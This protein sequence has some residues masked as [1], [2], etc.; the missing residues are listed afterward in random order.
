ML[1]EIFTGGEDSSGGSEGDEELFTDDEG[2]ENEEDEEI[3]KEL[4]EN[5]NNNPGSFVNS[6]VPDLEFLIN[7][8][9]KV[10]AQ[11]WIGM[12]Y[13]LVEKL[14]TNYDSCRG[15]VASG[16][17]KLEGEERHLMNKSYKATF[18][19]WTRKIVDKFLVLRKVSKDEDNQ[20]NATTHGKDKSV[21]SAEETT[22]DYDDEENA[23]LSA[24][25]EIKA[26][27]RGDYE[28]D[29]TTEEIQ[30]EK[31]NSSATTKQSKTDS[32]EDTKKE[33]SVE[34]AEETTEETTE[35]YEDTTMDAANDG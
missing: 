32:G 23:G 30:T 21:E 13:N 12:I 3:L 22:Q 8:K 24:L 10:S 16:M 15:L 2:V 34:T 29:S 6:L 20:R 33:K 5:I 4:N 35:D 25:E 9:G 31:A 18:L 11:I 27:M 19:D 28:E 17:C 1:E 26:N 7:W 14:V